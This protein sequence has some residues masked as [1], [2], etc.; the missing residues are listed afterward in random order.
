MMGCVRFRE[1]MAVWAGATHQP[2]P[3]A[4]L[5][6]ANILFNPENIWSNC[7]D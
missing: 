5:T 3:T 7:E 4:Q 1:G 2:A 6:T